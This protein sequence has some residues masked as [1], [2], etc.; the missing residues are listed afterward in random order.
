MRD[1]RTAIAALVLCFWHV[2]AIHAGLYTTAEP[3]PGPVVGKDGVHPLSFV[4]FR[5]ALNELRRVAVEQPDSEARRHYLKARDELQAKAR[6]GKLTAQEQVNLSHDLI[7]LRQYE[8]AIAVLSPAAVEERRN[9][10][11]FANLAAANQLAGRLDRARDYLEQVKDVWPREWPGLTREQLD[12]YRQAETYHLKLLRLRYREEVR[13]PA[14]RPKQPESVDA[15][16]GPPDAPVRFLGESGQYEAGQLAAAEKEKLPKDALAIV[17]QLLLWLPDDTRLY[18]LLGEVLNATG[19]TTSSAA[20]F[21]EC[22][23]SR[24]WSAPDLVE[25]RRIVKEF[26]PPQQE[27]PASSWLPDSRKLM[28]VGAVVGLL[29]V[30]LIYLQF[31]EFR[32]RHRAASASRDGL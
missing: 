20:V 31:R 22:L 13:Q 24:R 12:W 15:L 14:G 25:H 3:M 2:Q 19:D 28:V 27:Q 10:M 29:I 26:Q 4:E 7:R 21:E 8:E 9:F 18:W 1:L 5:D 30:V 23:W 6:T 11:V 17:Q 16:F 32:R